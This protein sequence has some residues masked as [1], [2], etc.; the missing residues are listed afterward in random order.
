MSESEEKQCSRNTCACPFCRA[1]NWL[2][3]LGHC[4]RSFHSSK[5]KNISDT[6]KHPFKISPIHFRFFIYLLILAVVL[7]GFLPE[8][9]KPLLG[10]FTA[11]EARL[12]RL[13]VM[14]LASIAAVFLVVLLGYDWKLLTWN[15]KQNPVVSPEV[16]GAMVGSVFTVVLGGLVLN[17]AMESS[18]ERNAIRQVAND[19]FNAKAELIDDFASRGQV[20]L[21]HTLNCR[22]TEEWMHTLEAKDERDRQAFKGHNERAPILRG[23]F[24]LNNRTYDEIIKGYQDSSGESIKAGSIDGMVTRLKATFYPTRELNDQVSRIGRVHDRAS[25]KD[26]PVEKVEELRDK[27]DAF[28]KCFDRFRLGQELDC[29][30]AAEEIESD[31]GPANVDH[32]EPERR[33]FYKAKT[34]IYKDY[35]VIEKAYMSI[36][37]SMLEILEYERTEQVVN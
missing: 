21:Y 2:C 30:L 32:I 26:F 23:P 24:D 7:V 19:H 34:K 37:A 29:G 17:H 11:E 12:W 35:A 1:W 13:Y 14:V 22:L 10:E 28:A 27:L 36:L 25:E 31:D 8:I 33:S 4:V 6:K 5:P 20:I 15:I 3:S 18:D 9:G 16:M